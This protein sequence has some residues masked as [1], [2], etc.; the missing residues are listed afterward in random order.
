MPGSPAEVTTTAHTGAGMLA[1]W[2]A[3]TFAGVDGYA[4]WERRVE[5]R[6][7]EAIRGGELVPVNIGHDG[8]YG[9]RLVTAPNRP[10]EREA[11]H[12][13]VTSEPYLLSVTDRR[14]RWRRPV[15][16]VCLSGIEFVGHTEDAPVTVN[17]V[18]GLY[19]VRAALLAWED[20]PESRDSDGN[21]SS[22]ALPDFVIQLAPVD[23]TEEFRS[24]QAT[25]A[26]LE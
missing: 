17:L 4:E 18:P 2:D 14:S 15:G 16:T 24:E 12:T 8:A 10:T 1:L 20:D 13:V 3:G 26:S 21:L 7:A 19:A 22:Y 11:R 9:V 5:D 25:F 6:L 23:G